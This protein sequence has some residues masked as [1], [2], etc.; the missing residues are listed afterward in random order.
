[1]AAK[2]ERVLIV[3]S[4]KINPGKNVKSLRGLNPNT[5]C[6]RAKNKFVIKIELISALVLLLLLALNFFVSTDCKYPR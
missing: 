3:K 4:E 2:T 5:K 1:M 6:P